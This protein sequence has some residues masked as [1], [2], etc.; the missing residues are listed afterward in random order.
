MC[1]ECGARHYN[2]EDC[3]S[4]FGEG[5]E[6]DDPIWGLAPWENVVP[7]RDWQFLPKDTGPRAA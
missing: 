7:I 5:Q 6:G 3:P 2:F 4:M 1:K